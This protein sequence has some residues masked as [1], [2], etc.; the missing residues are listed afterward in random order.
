MKNSALVVIDIQKGELPGLNDSA[1]FID[2]VN[3]AIDKARDKK[4]RVIFS[5]H[6]N[7]EPEKKKFPK[8]KTERGTIGSELADKLNKNS[9]DQ[10]FEKEG[11]SVFS[12]PNFEQFLKDNDIKKLYLAGLSTHVCVLLSSADAFSKGYE[13]VVLSE[14]TSANTQEKY[15]MGIWWMGKYTSEVMTIEEF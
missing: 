12:N 4:I 14:A 15:S 3:S 7:S 1:K 10:V 9:E 8:L 2:K 5:K 6:F 13:V 11:Y